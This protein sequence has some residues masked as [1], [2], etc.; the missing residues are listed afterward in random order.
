MGTSA[1]DP[2]VLADVRSVKNKIDVAGISGDIFAVGDVVRYEPSTDL[3]VLAKANNVYN[4]NFI[5]IIESISSTSIVLVYS[6]EIS[7]PDSVFTGMPAGYTGAQLFYLSDATSGKLTHIPPTNPGS[8]I[9][10]VMIISGKVIDSIEVPLGV[11]D[12]IVINSIG[13]SIVGDSSVDLSD[14][15][16]VGSILAFAGNSGSIPTGWQMC[17]GGLMNKTTFSDLYTSLNEGKLYGRVYSVASFSKNANSGTGILTSNNIVGSKFY[18]TQSGAVGAFECTIL[19]FGSA[20]NVAEPVFSDLKIFVSPTYTNGP[21]ANQYHNLTLA[22]NNSGQVYIDG[23]ALN[24]V[25]QLTTPVIVEFKKPDLRARFIVGDSKDISGTAIAG[26][27]VYQIGI[28]GGE[29]L[30]TLETRELPIHTHTANTT[31]TAL[32]SVTTTNNLSIE[33]AG[34]HQ[35]TF[36]KTKFTSDGSSPSAT[37]SQTNHIGPVIDSVDDGDYVFG[38]PNSYQ[39]SPGNVMP[40]NTAYPISYY[41]MNAAGEHSHTISGSIS[42]STANLLPDATTSVSNAGDNIE[43]NNVP[44]YNAM[45]WIIKTRKDS[46]AKILKLGPSGGGAVIAKNTA[47]RWV[48]STS[49]SGCTNDIGYGTWGVS[50]ISQGNYLFS[51]DMLSELGTAD[52]DKYIVETSVSKTNAGATQMFIAN[53]YGYN[54]TTF[55]V[56]V[57]EVLGATHSDNFQYLNITIYGGNTAV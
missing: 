41:E 10:P 49:G 18:V 5:G 42:I 52:Q 40:G 15:Q 1:F 28:A 14:I 9:K 2:V 46:Y 39:D 16:P 24:A 38:A 31:L 7:L 45:I 21:Q 22:N 23:V 36:T 32:G 11:V 4:S 13:Q 20:T 12:G 53:A 56:R 8:V 17:D 54:G 30:H 33:T 29:E 34:A 35:H 6:G 43:H 27:N 48:R 3:Y 44:Q 47:K 55:G 51:H 26:F 19:S 57:W 25:Y 50:R 37:S